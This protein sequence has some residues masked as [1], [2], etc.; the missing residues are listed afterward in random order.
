[1]V[2]F[3]VPKWWHARYLAA[4]CYSHSR[5]CLI[6]ASLNIPVYFLSPLVTTVYLS[7]ITQNKINISNSQKQIHQKASNGRWFIINQ[8]Y[9]VNQRSLHKNSRGLSCKKSSCCFILLLFVKSSQIW[10]CYTHIGDIVLIEPGYKVYNYYTAE[11]SPN[12]WKCM[13]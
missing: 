9:F 10:V 7:S 6:E 3:V 4:D 13:A 12:P 2:C 5:R 8:E 11:R 1:M